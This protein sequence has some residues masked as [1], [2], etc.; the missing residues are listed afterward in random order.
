LPKVGKGKRD[1]PF[2]PWNPKQDIAKFAASLPIDQ[3]VPPV[4]GVEGGSVAGREVLD[5]FVETKLGHYADG[6]NEPDAPDRT[7]A[8]RLSSYLHYGHISI[9]EVAEAAL[10]EKWTPKRINPKT[11]N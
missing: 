9:Q 1:P 7:A 4:H 2:E 5:A 3:S 10:G 8:S 11:R 6:R